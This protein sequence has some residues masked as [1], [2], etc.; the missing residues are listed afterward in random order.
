MRRSIMGL[1]VN[2]PSYSRVDSESVIEKVQRRDLVLG[3]VD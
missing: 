3:V 2:C 1:F